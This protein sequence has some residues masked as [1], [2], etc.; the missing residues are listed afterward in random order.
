MYATHN[1]GVVWYVMGAVGIVTTF[2]LYVYGKWTYR[3]AMQL[4]AEA[5]ESAS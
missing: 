4:E 1:I 3:F 5:Q 2:G